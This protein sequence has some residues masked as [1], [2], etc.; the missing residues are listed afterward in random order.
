MSDAIFLAKKKRT[1][2]DDEEEEEGEDAHGA[3]HQVSRN[4]CLVNVCDCNNVSL[5]VDGATRRRLRSCLV[6]S[7]CIGLLLKYGSIC[8]VLYNRLQ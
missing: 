8:V 6:K 1:D 7:G 4:D 3:N 2:H 5:S